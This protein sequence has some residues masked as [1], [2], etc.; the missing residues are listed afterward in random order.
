MNQV[1]PSANNTRTQ[2]PT[3]MTF[4]KN[5]VNNKN[6]V[7]S[8]NSLL[9]LLGNISRSLVSLSSIS[10]FVCFSHSMAFLAD[11]SI[12]GTLKGKLPLVTLKK[13]INKWKFW[14]WAYT[15]KTSAIISKWLLWKEICPT[16]N[17]KHCLISLVGPHTRHINFINHFVHPITKTDYSNKFKS[18]TWWIQL[19]ACSSSV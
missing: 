11:D 4:L 2:S 16:W 18:Y 7:T 6:A 19:T 5:W 14:F 17:Y 8:S 12:V 9:V 1:T 13:K 10:R 3:K 15:V